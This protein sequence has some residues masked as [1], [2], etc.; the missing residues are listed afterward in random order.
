MTVF[1]LGANLGQYTLLSAK[2]VGSTGKVHS[3]EP[4]SRMFEELQFNVSLNNLSER[5]TLNN[6]AV[7]N[8][9][10]S[11]TL[12]KCAPGYEVYG[13]LG[14]VC[15]PELE[16]TQC[17]EV[18]TVRLDDYIKEQNIARVDFMKIDIEGAE[19]LALQGA[20]TLLSG[21]D[22]PAI[23]IEL[24]DINA[25]GFGYK[26]IEIWDFLVA[27]GYEILALDERDGDVRKATRPRDSVTAMNA[28]AL[29][30]FGRH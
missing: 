17:E 2:R 11:A 14:A 26:A 5:C 21:P 25:A 8:A 28:V 30:N 27:K 1:D 16:N 13:S 20:E 10:G 23:L 4:S 3:F 7:S 24:A 29:K 12:A 9:A 22:A 18:R 15:R 6:V 19:L